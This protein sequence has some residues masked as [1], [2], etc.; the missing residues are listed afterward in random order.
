ML[1]RI[2]LPSQFGRKFALIVLAAVLVGCGSANHENAGDTATA[3]KEPAPA[4][5]SYDRFAGET[6]APDATSAAA[7]AGLPSAP[8]VAPAIIK[9][10]S[11]TV[12]TPKVEESEREAARTAK[13]FGGF[14]SG[15]D[16]AMLASATPTVT[17]EI[18]IPQARFADAVSAFEALGQ[19]LEKSIHAEDVST[20]LV[21]TGARMKSLALEEASLNQMIGQARRLSDMIT[22]RDRQSEIRT[23]IESL[24]A[25]RRNMENRVAYSSLSLTLT[26]N[27]PTEATASD[28]GWFQ[29][30]LSG[31]IQSAGELGRS[32]VVMLVNVAVFLPFWAIPA[33]VAFALY[34]R[35][36]TKLS[37]S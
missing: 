30:A 9:T 23:E 15:S 6:K 17:L 25:Q 13:R 31:S 35:R 32:I 10:A 18:Q 24:A 14:V 28:P 21:D 11:L 5:V 29:V 33:A 1:Q 22:L 16:G 4:T 8:S 26:Q 34:H 36:R 27:P 37:K 2:A 19:R 20:Q 12:R 7:S 3:A